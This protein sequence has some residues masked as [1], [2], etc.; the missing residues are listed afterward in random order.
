MRIAYLSTDEVN[1][2]LAEEMAAACGLTLYPLAPK[3]PP[4]DETFDAVLCDGDSWL[5]RQHPEILAQLLAGC[6]PCVAAIHGYNLT[7]GQA[8]CLRLHAVAV[9]R[10]LRPRLF[11]LLQ[12]AA[13]TVRAAKALGGK[14]PSRQ[15]TSQ[16]GAF[17]EPPVVCEG[18]S[19][20]VPAD[21]LR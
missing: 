17:L 21:A 11:R 12:R 20:T 6:R 14:P 3:D 8:E 10:R 1:L 13:R 19:L 7:D 9:Y 16:P 4:P 18:E 15:A 5:I 2:H